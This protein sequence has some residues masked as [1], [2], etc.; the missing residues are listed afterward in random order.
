MTRP[1]Y[2]TQTDR[3]N[4]RRLAA[5]IEKHY[6]CILQK[7]PMKLS[8]D[9]MAIRDGKAVAFI[10]ARQRKIAMNTYPT[11]MLSLYKAMQARSLTMT[12]GLPCFLAVQWTDKAGIAKLPPA[13]EE[14]HVVMGGTTRRDD[15]QDIEPMVHF[16]IANFKE[17]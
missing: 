5:K 9:F 4:E 6:G 12:T 16:D 3:N 1:I 2:E 8:L 7:M 14:M 17:L 13:H 15:P 11:Y 10:E